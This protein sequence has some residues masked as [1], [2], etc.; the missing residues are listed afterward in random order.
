MLIVMTTVVITII[1]MIIIIM[2]IITIATNNIS[3]SITK[4]HY[5]TVTDIFVTYSNNDSDNNDNSNNITKT[6]M[7]TIVCVGV[8]DNQYLT[9]LL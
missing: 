5:C 8:T 2:I 1:I 4:L 9:F 6:N 3:F 7:E